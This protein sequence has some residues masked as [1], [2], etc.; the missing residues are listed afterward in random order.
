MSIKTRVIEVDA[1]WLLV[2][3]TGEKPPPDRRGFFLHRTVSDW[4]NDHPTRIVDQTESIHHEGELVG[5][6]VWL[7]E[8]T[9]GE[10]AQKR[11]AV[12]EERRIFGDPDSSNRFPVRIDNELVEA[13]HKEHLEALIDHAYNIFLKDEGRAPVMAVISRG[14]LAVVLERATSQSRLMRAEKL[15]LRGEAVEELRRW[16]TAGQTTYFVLPMTSFDFER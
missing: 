7:E 6:H 13:V 8:A 16:Q 14:G 1:C 10:A 3:F 12:R 4:L 2:C 9:A 5:L 11:A 15:G